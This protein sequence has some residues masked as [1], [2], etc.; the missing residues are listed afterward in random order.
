MIILQW[1]NGYRSEVV[2]TLD[3]T[4]PITATVLQV[5][6]FGANQTEVKAW[7]AKDA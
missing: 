5:G 6:K 1:E 3:D 7:A 4:I 2:V